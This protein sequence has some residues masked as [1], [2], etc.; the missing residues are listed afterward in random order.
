MRENKRKKARLGNYQPGKCANSVCYV[1][2]KSTL[3]GII[4][5][6][7]WISAQMTID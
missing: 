6:R 4:S 3:K 7:F 5:P 1:M 2:W